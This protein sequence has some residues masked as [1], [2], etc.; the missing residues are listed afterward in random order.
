MNELVAG[1]GSK[2]QTA[3]NQQPSKETITPENANQPKKPTRA[4][5][6]CI[7]CKAHVLHKPDKCPE[8][9]ANKDKRWKGW[10]LVNDKA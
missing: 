1:K 9:E 4:K 7:H 2:K 6:T 10:K 5:H 3:T 8:L